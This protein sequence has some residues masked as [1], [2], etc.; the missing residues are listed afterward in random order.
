MSEDLVNQI[1][2]NFLISKSQLEKLNKKMKHNTDKKKKNNI[3]IYG[4]RIIE[5]F[6]NLLVCNEPTDL[7]QEV[8][9]GFD[10]FIDKCIYYFK[11][12]DDNSELEHT[13]NNATSYLVGD[14]IEIVDEEIV[15]EEIEIDNENI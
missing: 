10:F 1:T 11:L 3:D 8:K 13:R 15:D 9:T 7:L 6:N 2:L 5:L 12:H 4:D 14:E